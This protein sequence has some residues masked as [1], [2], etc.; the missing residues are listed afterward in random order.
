MSWWGWAAV[1]FIPCFA[2]DLGASL[3]RGRKTWW[4]PAILLVAWVA[5]LILEVV[6]S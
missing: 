4:L 6:K 5:I 3:H 1:V 2:L